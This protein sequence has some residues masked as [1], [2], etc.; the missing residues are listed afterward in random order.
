MK[1]ARCGHRREYHRD[2]T[3]A[4]QVIKCPCAGYVSFYA[5]VTARDQRLPTAWNDPRWVKRKKTPRVRAFGSLGGLV[6]ALAV[7]ACGLPS[8][9]TGPKLTL[10]WKASA[11]AEEYVVERAESGIFRKIAHVPATRTEYVDR[12]VRPGVEYCYQVRARNRAG[13]S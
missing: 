6:I 8:F 4:C 3:G 2:L 1:C 7:V 9:D 11:G 13:L 10:A 12:T 5:G